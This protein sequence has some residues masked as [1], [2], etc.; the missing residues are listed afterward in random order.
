MDQEG[1]IVRAW[2][3]IVP[4]ID[5]DRAKRGHQAQADPEGVLRVEL[6]VLTLGNVFCSIKEERPQDDVQAAMLVALH[7]MPDSVLSTF[8]QLTVKPGNLSF[9]SFGENAKGYVKM[10]WNKGFY[11][12]LA[13]LGE[14]GMKLAAP[15]LQIDLCAR[16]RSRVLLFPRQF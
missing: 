12:Y 15:A 10:G 3:G 2:I 9:L 6:N 8:D 7:P 14:T 16:P 13:E 1:L 4:E 5:P 11:V